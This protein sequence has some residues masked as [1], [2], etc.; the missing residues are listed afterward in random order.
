M[1]NGASQ[2]LLHRSNY[3]IIFRKI[4]SLDNAEQGWRHAFH[5]PLPLGIRKL[6]SLPACNS[7][8]QMCTIH[9]RTMQQLLS[10]QNEVDS[11]V[12]RAVHN[13]K[14][15]IPEKP[16]TTDEVRTKRSL[17]PGLGELLEEL[18]GT[19]TE[20]EVKRN[21][22]HMKKVVKKYEYFA[23]TFQQHENSFASFMDTTDSRISN[24][25]RG[26]ELN[27]EMI[28]NITH[29]LVLSMDSYLQVWSTLNSI[30]IQQVR[31]TQTIDMQTQQLALGVQEAVMGK[32]SPFLVPVGVL[33][34]T[35]NHIQRILDASYPKF[36]IAKVNTGYFYNTLAIT[37][38]RVQNVLILQLDVPIT[39][40]FTVFDVYEVLSFPVPINDSTHHA[41][42]LLDFPPYFAASRDH[43]IEMTKFMYDQCV[44][45]DVKHCPF[46]LGQQKLS[47]P[48]CMSSIFY[49]YN[50]DV[51]NYC[52]FRFV[53]SGV[54]SFILELEPG[55]ILM[56]EAQSVKIDCDNTQ[57]VKEFGCKFCVFTLPCQCSLSTSNFVLPP[58]INNCNDSH[59]Q[60]TL[61]Y[62]INLALLQ[63]FFDASALQ[64]TQGDTLFNTPFN[65]TVPPFKLYEHKLSKTIAQDHKMHLSL[66]HMV[67]SAKAKQDIYRSL[68]DPIIS[69]KWQA[70]PKS[71]IE[72][73]LMDVI[74]GV[75]IV[76][77]ICVSSVTAWKQYRY[78]IVLATLTH[79]KAKAARIPPSNLVWQPSTTM[80]PTDIPY[81]Q[82]RTDSQ[83]FVYF[84]VIS[85]VVL[86]MVVYRVYKCILKCQGHTQIILRISNGNECVRICVCKLR[87]CSDNIVSN[88]AQVNV[89]LAVRIH[90]LLPNLDLEWEDYTLTNLVQSKLI[91]LPSGIYVGPYTAYRINKIL[92]QPNQVSLYLWHDYSITA[93]MVQSEQDHN[94]NAEKVQSKP[95]A[96]S[97]YPSL[98]TPVSLF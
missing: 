1:A 67:Q 61:E 77:C 87:L 83:Y 43:Y 56:S 12:A 54:K 94:T 60:V 89:K 30:M 37:A 17:V 26:I 92:Q 72:K 39:S 25:I 35:L 46:V 8:E 63:H 45:Q 40:S 85:C 44:G 55:K 74:F 23:N 93:P 98:G 79:V 65:F 90:R 70:E 53:H 32:L 36:H 82:L 73:H 41:S 71:F 96:P 15:L 3:G 22:K 84:S 4:S 59:S 49:N 9:N 91:E 31:H 10:L 18:A 51:K 24:A 88:M 86:C 7:E 62:P 68:T 48:S 28:S 78:G 97:L 58:R 50:D 52:D 6:P 47:T 29:D 19:A 2:P 66:K 13:I 33:N 75:F 95:S 27:H 34:R 64:F 76:Y 80:H 21:E 57:S 42:Q 81:I 38:T 16:R 11:S 14:Q 20:R 5:I 69:G